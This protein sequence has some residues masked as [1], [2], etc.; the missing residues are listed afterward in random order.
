VTQTTADRTADWPTHY[1]VKLVDIGED[2]DVVI[3]GHHEDERRRVVAALHRHSQRWGGLTGDY[4]EVLENLEPRWAR[5]MTDCEEPESHRSL[6]EF[7]GACW[8]CKEIERDGWH[9]TWGAKPSD[10]GAF[11][12]LHWGP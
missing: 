3:L 1:G 6:V 12:I 9:L 7:D 5:F 11:P 8:K 4:R 2:G 10:P